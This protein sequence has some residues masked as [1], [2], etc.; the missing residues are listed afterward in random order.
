VAHHFTEAGLAVEAIEYWLRAG[1]R[2]VL[3]SAHAEAISHFT[4]AIE[5]VNT[6]PDTTDRAQTELALHVAL[7]P[8]L[9]VTKGFAAPE[10]E[11]VYRRA[12][13][14]C[15]QEEETPR[16]FPVLRGL[17]EFYEL[18]AEL[19]TAREL[20]NKLINVAE[21]VQDQALLL[22]ANDALGDTSL[23]LGEFDRASE[24]AE[25]GIRLYQR[26]QHHSL[27]P[28]YGGYDPGVAC[29][30]FA[31]H[32]LWYL[33]YPDQALKRI[34]E[35]VSLGRELSHPFSLAHALTFAAWLHQYRREP[36]IVRE[37]AD[38]AVRLSTE[39]GIAFL[40]PHGTILRGWALAHDETTEDCIAQIHKGLADYQAN[41]AELE[42][43]HWL[44]LL[45]DTHRR[46][47]HAA[48]GL[49][50]IEAAL[51]V[52]DGRGVCFC[53]AELYRL[54]GE[55]L[56]IANASPVEDA[57]ACFHRALDVARRQNAKSVELRA[58]MSLARL[59]R[60]PSPPQAAKHRLLA[61]YAWFTEGLDTADLKEAKALLD[62]L[63][64]SKPSARGAGGLDAGRAARQPSM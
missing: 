47:G 23:W 31:A 1:Q 33:G 64:E 19:H 57:E 45:A 56:L 52:V 53:E 42:R 14:L 36:H 11:R 40:L 12:L 59:W 38:E 9:M 49:Q 3:R 27:A 55:L 5:L 20:A 22:V 54:R 4:K 48:A 43:P 34:H 8:A 24:H 13:A 39:Q 17:W 26:T 50:A 44:A 61:T 28:L 63:G 16:L 37:L 32:A 41:G 62:G 25:R 30:Y 51:A 18:R 15:R 29:R 6:L 35:A 2:A 7:G 21:R 58:A 60:E 10:V 46:A